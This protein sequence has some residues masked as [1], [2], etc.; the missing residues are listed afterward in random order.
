MIY[1]TFFLIT[2]IPSI[3]ILK[4]ITPGYPGAVCLDGS[5]SIMYFNR[6]AEI[7][8]FLIHLYGGGSCGDADY[9]STI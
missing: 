5:P 3:S 6:G 1:L 7:N 4:K 8:K 2:V 9:N